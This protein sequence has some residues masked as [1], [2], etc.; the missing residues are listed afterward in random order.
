MGSEYVRRELLGS[1]QS[2]RS[3]NSGSPERRE[4]RDES[5]EEKAVSVSPSRNI[6]DHRTSNPSIMSGNIGGL[7]VTS[8]NIR[9][10]FQ[11]SRYSM[12]KNEESDSSSSSSMSSRSSESDSKHSKKRSK[13]ASRAESREKHGQ[14]RGVLPLPKTT[15]LSPDHGR[16]TRVSFRL[17]EPGERP[18]ADNEIVFLSEQRVGTPE[19][20]H[21]QVQ[22]LNKDPEGLREK[23]S[24]I[25]EE[26]EEAQRDLFLR[27]SAKLGP[28]E[29]IDAFFVK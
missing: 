25:P 29:R 26:P 2:G 7:P 17:P 1:R 21:L 23:W 12:P 19:Q 9:S 4:K 6:L 18:A 15:S 8:V 22:M 16:S 24:T 3:G 28:L 14:T 10:E 11:S 27:R 20:T 5:P 13:N